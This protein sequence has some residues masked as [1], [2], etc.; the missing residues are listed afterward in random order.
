MDPTLIRMVSTQTCSAD[1]ITIMRGQVMRLSGV[2]SMIWAN[3][4]EAERAKSSASLL[5][6]ALFVARMVKASCDVIIGVAGELY[7]PAKGI[8]LF[9]SGVTPAAENVVGKGLAGQTVTAQDYASAANAGGH[10]I[11]KK[12]GG[13]SPLAD[14]ADYNKVKTDVVINAMARDEEGVYKSLGD[15]TVTLSAWAVETAGKTALS[16]GLK[17]GAELAKGGLA[18]RDAIKDWQSGD[19][20]STFDAGIA[21][22]RRQLTTI[23]SRISE[24]ERTLIACGAEMPRYQSSSTRLLT[25]NFGGPTIRPGR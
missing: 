2:R 19:M 18:Y 25:G 24:L 13:T 5:N 9:Y 1:N 7:P 15:Y 3:I 10:A 17:V 11:L 16:K 14:L 21:V 8:S 12:L 20:D 23:T 22:S 4:R 6:N